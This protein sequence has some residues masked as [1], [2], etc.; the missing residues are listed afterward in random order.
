MKNK[1]VKT[2][3]K[4]VWA[5]I[6]QGAFSEC[7]YEQVEILGSKLENDSRIYYLVKLSNGKIKELTRVFL[8]VIK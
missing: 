2:K 5:D 8:P 4:K 6:S 1:L 7:R 3:I